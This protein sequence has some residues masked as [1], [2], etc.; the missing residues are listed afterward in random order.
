MP[1]A[2]GFE[3]IKLE[4]TEGR[5]FGTPLQRWNRE[6]T[7]TV[8]ETEFPDNPVSLSLWRFLDP[9][10]VGACRRRAR[11]GRVWLPPAADH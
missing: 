6:S 9:N 2:N 10:G 7:T 1:G 11:P 8:R 4:A 3:R 5:A